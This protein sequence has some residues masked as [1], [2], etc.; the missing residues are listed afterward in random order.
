MISGNINSTYFSVYNCGEMIV[1]P[2]SFS[3]YYFSW[4]PSSASGTLYLGSNSYSVSMYSGLF[5]FNVPSSALSRLTLRFSRCTFSY[6]ETNYPLVQTSVSDANSTGFYACS[7]MTTANLYNCV[8]LGS[9]MF[10]NTQY[11]EQVNL[12]ICQEI[13]SKA[14]YMGNSYVSLKSIYLPE[15]SIIR[16]Y[17]F[18]TCCAMSTA[19]VPECLSVESAGF[20]RCSALTSIVMDKCKYIGV[21]AFAGCSS[22]Y[23]VNLSQCTYIG[24]GA[25]DGCTSLTILTL[26]DSS[27]CV[28]DDGFLQTAFSGTK[29]ASSQGG[30]YVPSSLVNDYKTAMYWSSLSNNIY[31]IQ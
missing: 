19:Y 29:I 22:L 16:Q 1:H 6:F 11:L 12:P 23:S 25:F 4:L 7:S 28:L 21:N 8:S 26:R 9:Q 30:I 31:P 5:S 17:A 13:G 18:Y 15:C 14:F 10:M 27:V 20:G 3:Y 2:S 24:T